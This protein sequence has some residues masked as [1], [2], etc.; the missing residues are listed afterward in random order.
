MILGIVFFLALGFLLFTGET[1]FIKII[2]FA[3]LVMTGGALLD[4]WF[5]GKH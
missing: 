3:L 5:G 2:A 1:I 4:M